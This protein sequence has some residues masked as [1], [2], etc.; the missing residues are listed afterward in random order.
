MMKNF[1]NEITLNQVS[2]VAN[3]A[4]TA[5]CRYFK[6]ATN[7]T[8]IQFINELRVGYAHR[9]LM[10]TIKNVDQVCYESGF[11][12]VSNFYQQFKKITGK[13]PFR[14]RKE[15]KRIQL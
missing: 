10:G 2:A 14:Y 11:N 7:K 12:N 9:L 4:P 15:H 13:S 8:V 5:F 3:M 6:S 1:R